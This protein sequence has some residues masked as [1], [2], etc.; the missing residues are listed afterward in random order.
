MGS[1]LKKFV[2]H[3]C[4]VTDLLNPGFHPTQV[5]RGIRGVVKDNEGNPIA[6]ATVSV[7]GINHDVST[8]GYSVWLC[9]NHVP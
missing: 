2:Y 7:E 5:Q 8:G 6:N 3:C 1:P 4:R 9:V